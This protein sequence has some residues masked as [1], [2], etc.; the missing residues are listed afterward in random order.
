M[1]QGITGRE[2]RMTAEHMLAY[3]TCVVAGVTPGKG[4]ESVH[5]VPVF[6]T[7]LD[8]VAALGAGSIGVSVVIVPPLAT[9]QAVADVV[10]QAGCDVVIAT[11]G[12]PR[13]DVLRLLAIARD[14]GVAVVGPNSVGVIQPGRRRKL[15]AIGGD[16]PDRAF[17][18]GSIGVVSRS[19]GMTSEIGL[20]LKLAGLGVSAAISVGGDDAIGLPPASA[21]RLLQAVTG[22]RA[23]CYFGEPGTAFEEDLASAIAGGSLTVPV[24][25]LVAGTFTE[26]LPEGTAFGHAAAIIRR[27]SGRPS[28][29][30]RML[31][32]AGAIVVESLDDMASA[33]AG[34]VGGAG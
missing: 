5:G 8:A 9:L 18:P 25:A 16:R 31:A 3:G 4:G 22:T 33:V 28:D 24:V 30:R 23:I 17:V 2:G 32:E 19:G 15:G 27:G 1:I 26:S 13:H 34:L 10:Q 29:K 12:A 21:A 7:V 14:A 6:D 11:E 20:T